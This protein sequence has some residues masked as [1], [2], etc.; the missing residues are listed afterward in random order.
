MNSELNKAEGIILHAVPYGN[1]DQI[2]TVFTKDQG[3]IKLFCKKGKIGGR[4][5]TPLVKIECIFREGKSELHSCEEIFILD[6][7]LHLRNRLIDLEAGC[8][9]IQSVYKS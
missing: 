7:Y 5:F 3:V 6:S 2:L 8:H 4:R 9:L 1:Y